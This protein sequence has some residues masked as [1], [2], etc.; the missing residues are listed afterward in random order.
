MQPPQQK[1]DG[2]VLI[3]KITGITS[4]DVVEKF[5]KRSQVK[6]VG[7]TG[8]LDPLATGLLV[9]CVGKATRLQA[10]LMGMEKTYEGV[11]QFGWATDSYDASGVPTG[12][13]REVDV[14]HID[15]VPL[16]APF[17]G[18]IDQMPPQ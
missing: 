4:H 10:Y 12:E 6:K 11:I 1:V 14:E 2:V 3:D 8:T 15:F 5:R 9:L 18:E 16:V 7:H 17:L 13:K